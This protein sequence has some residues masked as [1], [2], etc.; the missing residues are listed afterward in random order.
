[1]VTGVVALLVGVLMC[2]AANVG[3]GGSTNFFDALP[4]GADWT[5]LSR[6]GG[7]ADSYDL[8]ADVQT[9]ITAAL[10]VAALTSSTSDPAAASLRAIWSSAGLY[11][12][13]R[14]T[15]NRYTTLMGKFVNSSGSNISV[16]ALSYQITFAGTTI[17]EEPGRGTRVYF[18]LTGLSN[19]WANLPALN[20]VA[21]NGVSQFSTNLPV[22]W[23]NGGNLFLLFADDN[24]SAG[25]DVA[26][27][28]D[29]FSLALTP[30]PPSCTIFSPTNGVAY[31][32]HLPIPFE[33]TADPGSGGPTTTG[34]GF[35]SAPGG[36]LA[37]VLTAPYT[38]SLILP[39]GTYGIYAVATNSLGS[40]QFSATNTIYVVVPPTNAAPP[41]ILAQAPASGGTVSNLSSIQVRFSEN[42]FNVQAADLLVNDLAATNVTGIGSN[43]VFLIAPPPFGPVTVRFGT[44]HGITDLG[45]PTDLAFDENGAGASWTYN[46]IDV[47]PPTLTARAPGAGATVTNL[48]QVSVTFSEPVTGLDAADLLLSTFPAS[49]LSGSG[50]NWVFTFPARGA[51]VVAVTW[52]TGH[53]L[54]DLWGNLFDPATAGHTW[55]YTNLDQIPPVVWSQNPPTGS[56]VPS[57]TFITV[58]FSENVLGVNASDLRVNGVAATAVSGGLGS[59]TF[60][61][62]W[63][64][65]TNVN[66]AW[67]PGHGI[68]DAVAPPNPFNAAAPG[69]TWSYTSLDHAAPQARV[70]HAPSNTVRS[71]THLNV[72]FDEPVSGVDAGDI[73]IN[74]LVATNV[75]GVG[76]GPYLFTFP[77]PPTGA[78]AVAWAAGHGITDVSPN[79]NPFLGGAWG[80]L[81]DPSLSVEYT[82]NHVVQMSLDGC[83]A[84]HLQFYVTN[85]PAQF[86]NFVRLIKEGAWTMNARCD[87][88]YSETVPNHATMFMARPVLQPAGAANTVHHGYNNNFPTPA[89]TFHNAGN[90]NLAYKS[91]MMDVAHDYGRSTALYT[92]KTRLDICDRS[93]NTTNGALDSTG[94]DHGRDKIDFGSIADISGSAISNEVTQLITNL[95]SAT[96]RNYS[97]IHLAEPDLTGHSSGWGSANWSNAVRNVDRE[98]GRI[99]NA[100]DTNPVLSNQT[101]LLITADHGGGGVTFNAHTEAYHITNYTVPFF[102]RAPGIQAG[103]DA[104][105]IFLNRGHPGTNRTD[106]TTQ[107]QPI[108]NADASN[109]AL[110][111]LGLP[112]IPGSFIVPV[113]NTPV[114]SLRVARGPAVTTVFWY[115][116]NNDSVLESAG[117]LVA[118]IEWQAV[119]VGLIMSDT[120]KSYTVTNGAAGPQFFRVRKL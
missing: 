66:V 82:V 53:G 73:L 3:P 88:E 83:A 75:S 42:V 47:F 107:P 18:S 23:L 16:V 113:L 117:E 54:Q 31:G 12:Q 108:R 120:T 98:I 78:V 2:S 76:A 65:D 69:A 28:L 92:G 74:G 101:A 97:F 30:A 37:S 41:A 109:L 71:L 34:L 104:Y 44:G 5:S 59:Y 22:N 15:G 45:Y 14:P 100:I 91:S 39:V 63:L 35:Y 67:T 38:N 93:Y 72:T 77:P 89:E 79:A 110:S 8:D 62:P 103:A 68:T 32:F 49:G 29:N 25:A 20:T 99:L 51:G 13:T 57:L 40:A 36:F 105:A 90:S 102:V 33:A 7:A 9:N 114:N 87:Y 4:G 52:A 115:D 106:Y 119:T 95:L 58:N 24:T 21:S 81:L 118:P 46:L 43:Y 80:Y 6:S 60:T 55:S 17:A 84:V 10:A 94:A 48:S 56:F 11:V 27:A 111:F 61:V 96:P 26:V 86:P 70:F 50:S 116:P 112:P 85:A 19:S 1:M 64:N